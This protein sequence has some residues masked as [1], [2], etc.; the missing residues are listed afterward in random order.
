MHIQHPLL[1]IILDSVING[2][3]VTVGPIAFKCCE[4]HQSELAT[5]E[6]KRNLILLFF[7]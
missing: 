2:H 7:I 3:L 6:N 4:I 5:K 1:R